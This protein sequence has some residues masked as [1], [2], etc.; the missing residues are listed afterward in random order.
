MSRFA[1]LRER[2]FAGDALAQARASID[3]AVVSVLLDAGADW[4]YVDEHGQTHQ[5]SE[6]LAIASLEAFLH[7]S[8]STQHACLL[9]AGCAGPRQGH[10]RRRRARISGV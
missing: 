10:Y 7:G 6:G 8:F 2:H 4:H 5:R 3:L 9:Q 1:A